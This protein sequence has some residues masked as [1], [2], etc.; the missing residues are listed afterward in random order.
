MALTKTTCE[1]AAPPAV[2][3]ACPAPAQQQKG[4]VCVLPFPGPPGSAPAALL[5]LPRPPCLSLARSDPPPPTHTHPPTH[6][7]TRPPHTPHT[8]SLPQPYSFADR[9]SVPSGLLLASHTNPAC[10]FRPVPSPAVLTSLGDVDRFMRACHR[11]GD[12]GLL[13]YV[14]APLVAV[15]HLVAGPDRWVGACWAGACMPPRR[16]SNC[17]D[18]RN[19]VAHAVLWQC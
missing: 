10:S 18:G 13:K 1:L 17:N 8:H 4:W 6:P 15:S 12:F 16:Q 14:P 19:C 11:C 9:F 5:L 3:A 7:P 2:P